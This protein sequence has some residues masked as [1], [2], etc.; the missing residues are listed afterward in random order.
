M[1]TKKPFF[2]ILLCIASVCMNSKVS[3]IFTPQNYRANAKASITPKEIWQKIY[4]K[5]AT[6]I[7]HEEMLE[8]FLNENSR[9]NTIQIRP[10]NKNTKKKVDELER[11]MSTLEQL[12]NLD[13]ETIQVLKD[14]ITLDR[15][16]PIMKTLHK[17]YGKTFREYQK[18][19]QSWCN[20]LEREWSVG[21]D[22]YKADEAFF[23]SFGLTY[24]ERSV[25]RDLSSAVLKVQIPE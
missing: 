5:A 6:S 17:K 1:K 25:L 19:I 18:T 8:N 21:Q 3:S 22:L 15:F 24:K 16:T 4:D 7:A 2:T 12:M 20:V 10:M 9:L 13:T 11:K 23:D 14:F